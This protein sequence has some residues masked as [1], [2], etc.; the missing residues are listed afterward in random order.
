MDGLEETQQGTEEQ[1]ADPQPPAEDRVRELERSLIE[2]ESRVKE[3]EQEAESLRGQVASAVERYRAAVLASA[4]DVPGELVQGQS[5]EEVDASVAKARKMVEEI[6]K[7]I[8]GRRAAE[9][10]PAGAPARSSPDLS[11]L[12]PKDKILYGLRQ[13]AG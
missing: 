1:R 8:E 10:V 5:I 6:A 4:P 11:A 13:K 3:R 2:M 9:R 7:K 12:S